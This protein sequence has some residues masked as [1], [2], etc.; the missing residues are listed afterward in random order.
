MAVLRDCLDRD[1]IARRSIIDGPVAAPAPR[2]T[3]DTSYTVEDALEVIPGSLLEKFEIAA[4]TDTDSESYPDSDDAGP[5]CIFPPGTFRPDPFAASP[6]APADSIS[7][8][9]VAPAASP[10]SSAALPDVMMREQ[11][12]WGLAPIVEPSA[13]PPSPHRVIPLP[14]F[15][16]APGIDF[17]ETL[18]RDHGVHVGWKSDDVVWNT[19]RDRWKLEA[20]KY[21]MSD[22]HY[23]E[24]DI[25]PALVSLLSDFLFRRCASVTI[26]RAV[27]QPNQADVYFKIKDGPP[28]GGINDVQKAGHGCSTYDIGSILTDGPKIGKN[29]KSTKRKKQRIGFYVFKE[30]LM[31]KCFHYASFVNLF[32]N[33]VLVAFVVLV[34]VELGKQTGGYAVGDQWSMSNLDGVHITGI[35][36]RLVKQSRLWCKETVS[37]F[38]VEPGWDPRLECPFGAGASGSVR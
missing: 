9:P 24:G 28:L 27:Y 31:E 13:P 35:H 36:A 30:S 10:V 34:H 15:G 11:G 16:A 22:P 32:G 38:L 37:S 4:A 19:T 8:C 21:T 33:G 25:D 1:R 23:T 2:S 14:K 17:S 26:E 29:A 7:P 6:A 5:F 20:S 12:V 3:A 18:R